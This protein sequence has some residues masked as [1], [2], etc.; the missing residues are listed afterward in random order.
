LV[1]LVRILQMASRV[2]SR[3]ASEE[4]KIGCGS[5]A[6][7]MIISYI[8]QEKSSRVESALQPLKLAAGTTVWICSNAL[9]LVEI[10]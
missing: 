7:D 9:I 2:V 3:Y 8:P 6:A 4:S 10:D 5:V 1:R